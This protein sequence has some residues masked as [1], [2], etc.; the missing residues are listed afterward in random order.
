MDENEKVK[1]GPKKGSNQQLRFK[2]FSGIRE[3][4]GEKFAQ[5]LIDQAYEDIARG[6]WDKM[7]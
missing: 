1:R 2:D 4:L 7:E 6:D 5:E 3:L